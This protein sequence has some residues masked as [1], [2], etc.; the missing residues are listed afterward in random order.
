LATAGDAVHVKE[1][2]RYDVRHEDISEVRLDTAGI[3]ATVRLRDTAESLIAVAED[4]DVITYSLPSARRGPFEIL[5]DYFRP[6]SDDSAG[7]AG[8]TLPLVRPAHSNQIPGRLT[9][10]TSHPEAIQVR[11]GTI[12]DRVYSDEFEAA[13]QCSDWESLES[14]D[15]RMVRSL[16][17]SQRSSPTFAIMD[18]AVWG[19]RLLTTITY[20]FEE[21]DDSLLFSFD[22]V[23]SVERAT[24]NGAAVTITELS[25]DNTGRRIFQ[26]PATASS[27][28][29]VVELS[30]FQPFHRQHELFSL[31]HPELPEPVG[32]DRSCTVL[33]V[34][35]QRREQTIFE[36]GGHGLTNIGGASDSRFFLQ[37]NVSLPDTLN[38]LLLT[39][40]EDV[41]Q[42][43]RQRLNRIEQALP[44]YDVLAGTPAADRLQVIVV[45]R[46]LL[47]LAMAVLSVL[48]YVVT[49]RV[50]GSP[51]VVVVA[52][53]V[54]LSVFCWAIVPPAVQLMML[55]MLPGMM[56]AGVAAAIQRRIAAS[57]RSPFRNLGE[58]D[59]NTVFAVEQPAKTVA[60]STPSTSAG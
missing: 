59:G 49:L 36:S 4:G 10:A 45:S 6:P 58:T 9:V 43:V 14:V 28:M 22:S 37:S 8:V 13:W 31:V 44:A 20:V 46:R 48:A 23:A 16:G 47:Y 33:W 56:I 60:Y 39:W 26:V 1:L 51:L 24:V 34:L 35:A 29:A 41:R 27:G 52:T 57:V 21:P 2:L 19:T 18:S 55:Q 42:E 50:S 53:T 17:G 38:S 5:V 12:W 54:I 7:G 25:D 15:L 3:N 11:A 32:M 40:P 30:V